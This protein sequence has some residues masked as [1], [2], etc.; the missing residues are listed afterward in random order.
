MTMPYGLVSVNN[1][2]SET[3]LNPFTVGPSCFGFGYKLGSVKLS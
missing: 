1:K 2:Y 3:S